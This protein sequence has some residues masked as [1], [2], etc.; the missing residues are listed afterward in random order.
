MIPAEFNFTATSD[1][2]W[3]MEVE[4][5]IDGAGIDWTGFSPRMDVRNDCMAQP[6]LTFSE[7]TGT[8]ID[9][10]LPAGRFTLVQP[11][12]NLTGDM[13]GTYTYDLA[14]VAGSDTTRILYGRFQIKRSTT[15]SGA[16]AG[17][18]SFA[19]RTVTRL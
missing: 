2:V 10:D 4:T 1:S 15:A 16:P 8:I 11:A 13:V 5:D 18:S 14:M 12:G 6:L 9:I 3:M 17:E 19:G 7:A